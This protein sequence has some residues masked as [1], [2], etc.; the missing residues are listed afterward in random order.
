MTALLFDKRP[1]TVPLKAWRLAQSVLLLG[2]AIGASIG[3]AARRPV[4]V[5]YVVPVKAAKK[6]ELLG[7]DHS[8]PPHCRH[9]RVTYAKGAEQL[10]AQ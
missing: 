3:C 1:I 2:C 5:N 9:E 4:G 7:C 10:V 8:S 6:I